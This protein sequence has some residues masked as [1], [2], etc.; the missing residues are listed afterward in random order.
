MDMYAR[1]STTIT[2]KVSKPCKE[3]PKGG[4]YDRLDRLK[5][6]EA[7]PFDNIV[8][9]LLDIGEEVAITYKE[10]MKNKKAESVVGNAR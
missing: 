4:T 8:S 9:R 3:F 1:G 10:T 5:L 7:E 2:I 6:F